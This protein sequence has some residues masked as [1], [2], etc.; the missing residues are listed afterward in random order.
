MYS[1]TE[2]HAIR[3]T[4]KSKHVFVATLLKHALERG[5][6][7]P[8]ER[9]H[10]RS[11]QGSSRPY[12]DHPFHRSGVE[13]N[14]DVYVFSDDRPGLYLS[15]ARR[16]I[17]R[18]HKRTPI[19]HVRISLKLSSE[20]RLS[21]LYP[22]TVVETDGQQ[23]EVKWDVST[24]SK[25]DITSRVGQEKYYGGP[26]WELS[27]SLGNASASSPNNQT[28]GLPPPS[29][30]GLLFKLFTPDTSVVLSVNDLFCETAGDLEGA[31][32]TDYLTDVLRTQLKLSTKMAQSF[33]N[34][35]LRNKTRT[36]PTTDDTHRP[37]SIAITF[38]PHQQLE[39]IAPLQVTPVPATT[40][41]IFMLWAE[42]NTRLSIGPW[43]AWY[44]AELSP[45]TA[46]RT[47]NWAQ[48]VG[49][50]LEGQENREKL[51]A[52]EWGMMKVPGTCLA[53]DPRVLH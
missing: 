4:F 37:R 28:P 46:L 27:P 43:A 48:I 51:T 32:M 12:Y 39:K 21:S 38:V 30:S 15:P 34:Y 5:Y 50:D 49:L 52:I 3:L 2:R 29:P 22:W 8:I 36:Q 16:P 6:P 13:H 23:E 53:K 20:L 31:A 11:A 17:D 45:A 1:L 24:S 19:P 25:G 9:L 42:V 41:R 14:S 35:F 7:G 33:K 10:F 18:G 47:K 44:G 26:S 40:S